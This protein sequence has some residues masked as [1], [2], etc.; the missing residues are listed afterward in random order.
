LVE[1][2]AHV[3]GIAIGR[4][5]AEERLHLVQSAVEQSTEAVLIVTPAERPEDSEFVYA[6]PAFYHLTGF[7][8]EE[9]IGKSPAL[10]YGPRT[11][12]E[13]LDVIRAALERDETFVGELWRY[14]RDGT[15]YLSESNINYVRD[16][17]G[18]VTHVVSTH[19]D[20]TE[21]REMEEQ[22]RHS[23]KMEAVGRLAGGMAHDFNNMLAVISG[24]TELLSLRLPAEAKERGALR[25]IARATER[26][27]DLTRRLLAFSRKQVVSAPVAD[28]GQ[29]VLKLEDLLQRLI[30]EDVLLTVDAQPGI[31]GVTLDADQLEQ[32]LINLAVNAR[33]AMPEGGNLRIQ[34]ERQNVSRS[35]TRNGVA[36]GKYL[37]I[38]VS[39]TGTGMDAAT[40]ARAFEPF[41]TTK[42]AGRGTG[43]GLPMVYGCVRQHHG[44]VELE[45]APGDGAT[46]RIY[47]P[48][49]TNPQPA[50]NGPLPTYT[51]GPGGSETVLLAEDEEMLRTLLT[52]RLRQ[53]GY[54]VLPAENGE[55]ALKVAANHV[56]PLDLVLTD[57]V[58]PRMGGRELVENLLLARP[59]LRVLYMSGYTEGSLVSRGMTPEQVAL[60]RKPFPF[61]SLLEKL[62]EV[63]DT[64]VPTRS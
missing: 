44:F 17:A 18:K 40:Q 24:Y 54:R 36:P 42:E 52:S 35:A 1:A 8:A 23:Q 50:T 5:E 58:M 2:V 31:G 16:A 34:V 37:L 28:V 19:R 48:L 30:G 41:F 56:G 49:T 21:R 26:A 38:T 4:A 3:A 60:I 59:E 14:R 27:T 55:A 57:V 39:D 11:R 47:L 29:L 13:E 25:E 46:F 53:A 9:V 20:V 61:E 45:S 33:D 62:R 6:N 12:Q 32:V 63:L 43:L 7:S 15:A 10:M 51:E 22:L 64:P